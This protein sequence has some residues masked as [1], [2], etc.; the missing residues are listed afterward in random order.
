METRSDGRTG[1]TP[2]TVR[3]VAVEAILS[4]VVGTS[5]FLASSSLGEE[6]L[7]AQKI[8]LSL[9]VVSI[10]YGVIRTLYFILSVLYR[11]G[12]LLAYAVGRALFRAMLRRAARAAYA[13]GV[14]AASEAKLSVSEERQGGRTARIAALLLPQH[15]RG[16]WIKD[17]A[18]TTRTDD[19]RLMVATLLMHV[20]KFPVVVASSWL[21]VMN[22]TSLTIAGL[23]INA[24]QLLQD[25]GDFIV[26]GLESTKT[27]VVR[28]W[29]EW[30]VAL[31]LAFVAYFVAEPVVHITTYYLHENGLEWPWEYY[32]PLH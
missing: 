19:G 5:L 1:V 17:V 3:R 10:G 24:Q 14:T 12:R 27:L 28:L 21:E 20:V 4:G 32:F 16:T 11:M 29:R 18:W 9:G 2:A 25:T 23:S 6:N 8:L 22:S 13:S 31:L 30:W 26:S 15:H 7:G